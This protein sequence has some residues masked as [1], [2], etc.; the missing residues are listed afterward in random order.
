[1][2]NLYSSIA[3][4]ES[5]ASKKK[6]ELS[7]FRKAQKLSFI[8]KIGKRQ[9]LKNATQIDALQK[10]EAELAADLGHGLLDMDATLTDEILSKKKDLSILRRQR[11]RVQ[12][13][14]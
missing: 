4:L 1:M 7:A 10:Q 5:I 6:A 8:P 3:D 9:Y 2:F 11:S 14:L 12:S 13:R